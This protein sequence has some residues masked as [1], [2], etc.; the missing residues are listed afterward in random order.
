M[1]KERRQLFK[2]KVSNNM[3]VVVVDLLEVIG[4]QD[5]DGEGPAIA[6]GSEELILQCFVQLT[7]VGNPGKPVGNHH[8]VNFFVVDRFDVAATD[9][10]E[11]E[12]ANLKLVTALEEAGLDIV[13]VDSAAVGAVEVF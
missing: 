13:I 12:G 8:P 6:L 1:L 2:D 4:V 3:A 10:L 7:S 11:D 5:R 9:I